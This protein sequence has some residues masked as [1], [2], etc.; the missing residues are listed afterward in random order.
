MR[1]IDVGVQRVANGLDLV[2]RIEGALSRLRIPPPAPVRPG[3]DLWRHTCCEAFVREP[4]KDAYREFNFSPSREWALLDFADYR[5]PTVSREI[6]SPHISVEQSADE[7][8]V[9]AGIRGLPEGKI[10]I[11]LSAVVEN[12]DGELSYWAL[13]HAP[14]KPDFHHP[15]SFA[16]DLQ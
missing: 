8:I 2:Y 6:P 16:L 12:V 13:R 5:K 14:G 10:S 1:K 7:L 4:G 3:K 11:G 15:D 9:R